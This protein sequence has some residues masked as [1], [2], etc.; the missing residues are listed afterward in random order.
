MV[1]GW[2]PVT[3]VEGADA[4]RSATEARLRSSRRGMSLI[5]IMVVFAMLLLMVAV[6]VPS[7][8][9]IFSLQQRQSAKQLVLLYQR[10]HDEAVLQ[11][12]SFR[13][14]FDLENGRYKVESG[15]AGMLI[16]DSAEAR[17]DAA[18]QRRSK[19]AL[20]NDEER[21]QHE[22]ARKPFEK[23]SKDL[24]ES[25][26]LNPGIMLGG[27]YTPQYGKM[28]RPTAL[29]GDAIEMV[30]AKGEAVPGF[31]YSYVFSSGFTE[32][33]VIWVVDE[34]DPE[35]GY[36]VEVEPLSGQIHLHGDLVEWEDRYDFVPDEGPG[37]ST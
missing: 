6:L 1:S 11:N 24:D 13:I 33:T 10:L 20:M 12:V 25:F 31:L 18:D 27:F 28:V 8:Q 19:L 7:M 3:D 23:L 17:E 2:A 4:T 21:M 32:H 37:L 16:F 26:E 36:T 15:E 29:G 14:A 22:K 35:S 34:D 5:E 30:D 9:S